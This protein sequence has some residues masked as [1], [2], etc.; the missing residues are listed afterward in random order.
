MFSNPEK[1]LIQLGVSDGM[2]VADFGAGN[3]AYTWAMSKKVGDNGKVYCI[4][5]QNDL[6]SKLS[7]ESDEEDLH[8]IEFVWSDIEKEK[9]STLKSD[10]VDLVVITN[11][12]FQ[13]ENKSNVAQE[14]FRITHNKGRVFFVEWADSFAGM[15]PHKDHIVP[16]EMAKDFFVKA[17]FIFER[18]IDAGDHHYGLIFIKN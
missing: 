2:I 3:G 4:D 10:S 18:E 9:G 15:G 14:S 17:G 5:I 13:V 12:F 1:N 8:N 16:K 11:T 7:K 6:L